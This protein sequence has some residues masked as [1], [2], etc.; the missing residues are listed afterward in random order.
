MLAVLELSPENIGAA[1]HIL[2]AVWTDSEVYQRAKALGICIMA[3]SFFGGPSAQNVRNLYGSHN[4]DRGEYPRWT[5]E[6]DALESGQNSS[7]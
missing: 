2:Q 4:F 1:A 7:K 3:P 6:V 5:E